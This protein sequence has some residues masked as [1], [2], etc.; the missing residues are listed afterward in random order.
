MRR[1]IPR[2]VIEGGGERQLHNMFHILYNIVSPWGSF[3]DT[4]EIGP[5]FES[6][7]LAILNNVVQVE[8]VHC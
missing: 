1:L 5:S 7:S 4:R 8:E 6:Q 3:G 2:P